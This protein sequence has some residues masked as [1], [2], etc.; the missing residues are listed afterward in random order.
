MLSLLSSA[1]ATSARKRQ[2]GPAN[3]ARKGQPAC[4]CERTVGGIL[5]MCSQDNV[6]SACWR[7]C[8]QAC[9]AA[10]DPLPRRY[11]NNV[12]HQAELAYAM[13]EAEIIEAGG[14]SER[15]F[16]GDTYHGKVQPTIG[17]PHGSGMGGSVRRAPHGDHMSLSSSAVPVVRLS[18]TFLVLS[19][20][21]SQVQT[22]YWRLPLLNWSRAVLRSLLPRVR[23]VTTDAP[24]PTGCRGF[25]AA[26]A[27][28]AYW[29][30]KST[31]K[32]LR[33]VN[34]NPNPKP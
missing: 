5:D 22:I 20:S 8:C 28:G 18:L 23:L 29:R 33:Q 2:P 31:A 11:H 1:A 7:T 15:A 25:G 12:Y 19:L 17:C 32:S 24:P 26:P 9:F 6:G 21:L 30:F 14:L 16:R 10:R 3:S 4:H 34:P 27:A 13:V